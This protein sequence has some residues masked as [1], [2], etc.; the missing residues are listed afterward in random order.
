MKPAPPVIR[1]LLTC[2]N[3]GNLLDPIKG[4][5][6]GA[7]SSGVVMSEFDLELLI[8]AVLDGEDVLSLGITRAIPPTSLRVRGV[9]KET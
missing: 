1:I 5:M 9:M 7:S 8:L 6:L 2:G 4:M 3:G